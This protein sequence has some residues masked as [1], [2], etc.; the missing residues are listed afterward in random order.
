MGSRLISISFDKI[1]KIVKLC[2]LNGIFVAS[3]PFPLPLPIVS[4]SLHLVIFKCVYVSVCA[5][6][7]GCT[8]DKA[9][10]FLGDNL[11]LAKETSSEQ[12]ATNQGTNEAS[13]HLNASNAANKKPPLFGL[14]LQLQRGLG[15]SLGLGLGSSSSCR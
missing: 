7:R 4:N 8:L 15:L 1:Y 10:S 6:V 3:Q 13:I 12:R 9:S 5:S 11:R 14:Q 2:S